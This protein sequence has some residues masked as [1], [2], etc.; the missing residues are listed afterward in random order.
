METGLGSSRKKIQR[1]GGGG[2]GGGGEDADFVGVFK[3]E[4]QKIPV[5]N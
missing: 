1:G 2:G 4:H 5:V 3:K